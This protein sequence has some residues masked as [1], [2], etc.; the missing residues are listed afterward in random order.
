MTD[1]VQILRKRALSIP[2]VNALKTTP[3]P[4]PGPERNL[5]AADPECAATKRCVTS[6][7]PRQTGNDTVRADGSDSPMID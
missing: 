5:P 1:T 2:E 7:Y 4:R 3:P 6:L